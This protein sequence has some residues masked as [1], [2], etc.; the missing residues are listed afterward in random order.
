[1]EA[2]EKIP[3]VGDYIT[4]K[5]REVLENISAGD[6]SVFLGIKTDI[7]NSYAGHSFR[8]TGILGRHASSIGDEPTS[9]F[10]FQIEGTSRIFSS[11]ATTYH[12]IPRLDTYSWDVKRR[13]FPS[14]ESLH[15][16]EGSIVE[17][18]S[19]E[20]L[21][22]IY[23]DIWANP[24]TNGS[25]E[26]GYITSN[27]A[28]D[29]YFLGKVHTVK[30]IY[31]DNR[32]ILLK[33]VP[34]GYSIHIGVIKSVLSSP[35]DEVYKTTGDVNE[36]EIEESTILLDLQPSEVYRDTIKGVITTDKY[37]TDIIEATIEIHKEF[38]SGMGKTYSCPVDSNNIQLQEDTLLVDSVESS[39]ETTDLLQITNF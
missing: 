18:F 5:S 14:V 39:F 25:F 13:S 28:T 23:G 4:F 36:K 3:K 7:L 31:S 22:S 33:D 24:Y 2:I 8:I 32:T 6:P 19:L 20:E 29:P 38:K 17:L 12:D 35:E 37:K 30:Q 21:R 34:D 9:F 11:K 16:K 1:M 27:M 10:Y 26:I 15:L